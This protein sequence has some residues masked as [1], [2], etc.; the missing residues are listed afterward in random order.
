MKIPCVTF[1]FCVYFLQTDNV[2]EML[3]S[4]KKLNDCALLDKEPY[5]KTDK[6][7]DPVEV[8]G[9][10]CYLFKHLSELIKINLGFLI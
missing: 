6:C 7:N 4:G 1:F 9:T 3:I 5:I 2:C 10:K 8:I